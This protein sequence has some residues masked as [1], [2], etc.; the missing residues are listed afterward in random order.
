M[1]FCECVKIAKGLSM[2]KLFGPWIGKSKGFSFPS[3]PSSSSEEKERK[4]RKKCHH[5]KK[6]P[7][8]HCQVETSVVNENGLECELGKC[9]YYTKENSGT[10]QAYIVPGEG[11]N[12]HTSGYCKSSNKIGES[13]PLMK[14]GDDNVVVVDHDN[15]GDDEDVSEED[16]G[17]IKPIL[18]SGYIPI[19]LGGGGMGSNNGSS[20]KRKKN[21]D[22][23]V[24]MKNC[25]GNTGIHVRDLRIVNDGGSGGGDSLNKVEELRCESWTAGSHHSA[26]ATKPSSSLSSLNCLHS[27]KVHDH[28]HHNR[29]HHHHDFYQK[30]DKNSS[31]S[32]LLCTVSSSSTG[33]LIDD[34]HPIGIGTLTEEDR[35][36]SASAVFFGSTSTTSNHTS[37]GTGNDVVGNKAFLSCSSCSSVGG[38]TPSSSTK[39]NGN[40]K[41][42]SLCLCSSSP[43]TP[44]FTN[45]TSRNFYTTLVGV[46]SSKKKSPHESSNNGSCSK[47]FVKVLFLLVL[48]ITMGMTHVIHTQLNTRSQ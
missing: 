24:D 22:T 47:F 26:S 11:C 21:A 29:H 7:N 45:D 2:K 5:Q 39:C 34:D 13:C 37:S 44:I 46:L 8:N 16:E 35:A 19:L 42:N 32:K 4:L 1:L 38:S 10:D 48:L 40:S 30:K 15:N 23:S 31:K 25:G 18:R 14:N 6:N 20:N 27:G 41:G 17:C 3:T 33:G 9:I 36:K 12:K 28:D 43:K